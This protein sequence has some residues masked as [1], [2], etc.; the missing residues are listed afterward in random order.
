MGRRVWMMSAAYCL[1][2]ASEWLL[3]P[4]PGVIRGLTFGVVGVV[5]A[6]LSGRSGWPAARSVG[7][8]VLAAVLL[9]G[10]PE[11][12]VG[13]ALRHVSSNLW[14]VVLAVV[15]AM[16][17]LVVAQSSGDGVRRLLGPALAGLGG[18]LLIVPLDVPE[19]VMGR[20]AVALLVVCAVV[21]AIASVWIHRLLRGFGV[22]QAIAVFC[23]ANALV[24]FAP[25]FLDGVAG[26]GLSGGRWVAMLVQAI[27]VV[28][29]VVLLRG[30]SPVRFG[31]R[32]LVVPLVT[33]VEGFVLLRP[34]VT[35]RMGFG[36]ALLAGSAAFLLLS[37]GVDKRGGFSLR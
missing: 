28:L 7:G 21:I 3:P 10:V 25:G 17:V 30:M 4:V 29:L 18:V 31:A 6:I 24:L 15:P 35:L 19:S 1:L 27:E 36:V 22:A 26:W 23:L 8:L 2:V 20:I 9:V 13:W 16:V 37:R 34:E 12:G 32:Y 11:V 5:A 33:V 14:V